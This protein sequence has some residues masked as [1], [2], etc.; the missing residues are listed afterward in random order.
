[1]QIETVLQFIKQYSSW[2]CTVS[3]GNLPPNHAAQ[4]ASQVTS[5]LSKIT[6]DIATFHGAH[7]ALEDCWFNPAVQ[8]GILKAKTI[9]NYCYSFKKFL[10]FLKIRHY[11]LF[12]DLSRMLDSVRNWDVSLK[13]A[14][15]KET[16]YLKQKGT[17]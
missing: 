16:H 5:I 7:L 2:L 1:M 10:T 4:M 17:I 8:K 15:R 12:P 6:F 13:Q 14:A 11:T 3:G 9:K